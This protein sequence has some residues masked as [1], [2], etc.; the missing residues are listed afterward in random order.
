MVVYDITEEKSFQHI[1]DWIND[2]QTLAPSS[3]ILALIGNKSDLEDKRKISKE[4][5][6]NLSNEYDML[7]FETSAL[8]GNGIKEAF[9]NCIEALDNRIRDGFY[10]LDESEKYGI[11]IMEN[12][13]MSGIGYNS[14]D[15]INL[16]KGIKKNKYK[17]CC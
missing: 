13:N 10:N 9:Q 17:K 5:G 3:A 8:N 12:G 15:K 4:T 7:F 11:K 2:C 6:E 14:V 16:S 1:K